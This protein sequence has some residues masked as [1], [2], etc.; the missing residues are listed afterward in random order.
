MSRSLCRQAT[1]L[2]IGCTRMNQQ[3]IRSHNSKLAQL[4]TGLQLIHFHS[5]EDGSKI[6][7]PA[8][9]SY[10]TTNKN[11]VSDQGKSQVIL[12]PER[13]GQLSKQSNKQNRLEF[14]GQDVK[15]S[16]E[17]WY[18]AEI[19]C[20]FPNLWLFPFDINTCTF[21]TYM[22]KESEFLVAKHGEHDFVLL[23]RD[24]PLQ[25]EDLGMYRLYKA[26]ARLVKNDGLA[27]DIITRR[28][29]GGV[30]ASYY[31]PIILISRDGNL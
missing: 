24:I 28:R 2:L 20:S 4:L 22:Y 13:K 18:E 16:V 9:A 29:F 12:I 10:L 31:L 6:W 23:F 3:P 25:P 14:L 26:N 8:F 19:L 15:I 7:K 21:I 5:R 30:F 27:I 11:I 1:W 17:R